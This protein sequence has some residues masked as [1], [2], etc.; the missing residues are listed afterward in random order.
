MKALEHG[1]SRVPAGSS[2]LLDDRRR[3]AHGP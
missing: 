2:E 1:K 3:V